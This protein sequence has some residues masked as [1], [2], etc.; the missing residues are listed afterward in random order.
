MYLRQKTYMIHLVGLDLSSLQFK[1]RN[2]DVD[3]Q[4]TPKENKY[5]FDDS[6]WYCCCWLL[7][8]VVFLDCC[9]L[10]LLLL[11]VTGD[12]CWLFIIIV[13]CCWMFVCKIMEN[14]L[15][16]KGP[17]FLFTSLTLRG[18][19]LNFLNKTAGLN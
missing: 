18:L 10:W 14:K 12:C 13:D 3:P 2:D 7:F 15:R 5:R 19:A 6:C 8:I 1:T 16:L 17:T 4:W 11:I 9:C